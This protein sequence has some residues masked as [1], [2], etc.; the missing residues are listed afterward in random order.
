MVYLDPG[1][2][3]CQ[4]TTSS[5]KVLPACDRATPSAT[6]TSAAAKASRAKAGQA[7]QKATKRCN[8]KS[9]RSPKAAAAK[10][11]LGALSDPQPPAEDGK[12]G[13][14][15]PVDSDSDQE[16][17]GGEGVGGV[18]PALGEGGRD[19]ETGASEAAGLTDD[20]MVDRYGVSKGEQIC[21]SYAKKEYKGRL[22]FAMPS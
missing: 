3:T 19:D 6:G 18:G 15:R 7:K 11:Q 13:P 1:Q 14:S 17:I 4:I 8:T 12:A 10:G 20:E 5:Y 9:A 16:I 21:A 22:P 2:I